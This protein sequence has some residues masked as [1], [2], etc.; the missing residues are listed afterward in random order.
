LISFPLIQNRSLSAFRESAFPF[1][2]LASIL[3]AGTI[4]SPQW[5][6]AKSIASHTYNDSV[7]VARMTRNAINLLKTGRYDESR[8]MIDSVYQIAEKTGWEKK[9]GDCYFNYSQIE[10]QRGNLDGFFENV[11]K[12]IQIYSNQ[13]AW[14]EAARTRTGIAQVHIG[15]KN[16]QAAHQH[17]AQSLELRE[18]TGDTLG[19]TNNLINIGNLFYLEGNHSDASAFFFRALRYAD[20]TGNQ[21]LTAIAT[22]DIFLQITGY[23]FIKEVSHSLRSVDMTG[24]EGYLGV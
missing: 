12:A 24:A 7:E 3:I 6:Y 18:L 14:T 8:M 5:I 19:I 4:I 21:G 9:I 17:F 11:E 2:T 20:D 13:K 22:N 15:L 23:Q 16:Y 10:R 1:I